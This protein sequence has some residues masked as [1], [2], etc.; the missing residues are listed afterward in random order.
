MV[1]E[2]KAEWAE[3]EGEGKAQHR[4]LFPCPHPR[5]FLP[6]D[7]MMFATLRGALTSPATFAMLLLAVVSLD[8][9]VS[10]GVIPP[11]TPAPRQ[12]CSSSHPPPILPLMAPSIHW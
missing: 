2:M 1:R 4:Q 6:K 8:I 5:F 10:T 7:P 3:S 11:R 9:L 12:Y